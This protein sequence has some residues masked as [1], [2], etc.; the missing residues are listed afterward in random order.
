MVI[1]ESFIDKMKTQK[2]L[3][4][5]YIAELHRLAIR[6]SFPCEYLDDTS[7]LLF[8]AVSRQSNFE[9]LD[10]DWPTRESIEYRVGALKCPGIGCLIVFVT[11][12][13]NECTKVQPPLAY[14]C[15]RILESTCTRSLLTG[16]IRKTLGKRQRLNRKKLVT[17]HRVVFQ[18]EFSLL[19]AFLGPFEGS[20]IEK[21]CGMLLQQPTMQEVFVLVPSKE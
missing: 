8:Y 16:S 13:W 1:A 21:V 18:I 4:A 11:H 10:H 12:F 17:L 19:L 5:T 20:A 9:R 6:C 15:A 14:A 2:S 3:I 7:T